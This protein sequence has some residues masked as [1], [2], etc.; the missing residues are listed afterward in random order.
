MDQQDL[1]RQFSYEEMVFLLLRGRKPTAPEATL[2]RAVIL[3]HASHG[4]TGQSTLAVRMAADCRSNFLH[5]LIAGF[6][7]GAGD[8]DQGALRAAMEQLQQLAEQPPA[9]LTD[10]VRA[11]LGRG[12]KFIGFGHRFLFHERDPRAVTL[13]QLANEVGF[14]GRHLELVRRIEEVLAAEKG[15]YMN[16]DGAG[17]AILLDLE[18]NPAIAHLIIVVGRAPM[19]AAAYLERLAEGHPPFPRIEVADLVPENGQHGPK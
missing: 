7:V 3:S 13:V 19:Y 18:L 14:A 16:I 12:E 15:V 9:E 17:G 1:I 2:L 6:S 5:A 8:Y 10:C 11:R 4:I